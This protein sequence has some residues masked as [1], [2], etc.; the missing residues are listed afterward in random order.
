MKK[1]TYQ[2]PNNP[3]LSVKHGK[4]HEQ[5]QTSTNDDEYKAT[6]E[7]YKLKRVWKTLET[8]MQN[9]QQLSREIN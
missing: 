7:R 9:V 6:C 8:N 2:K 1:S 3:R 4:W 5:H